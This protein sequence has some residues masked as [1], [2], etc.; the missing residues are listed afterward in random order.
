MD[1]D[2]CSLTYDQIDQMINDFIV[3]IRQDYNAPTEVTY[4]IHISLLNGTDS[5]PLDRIF[6][7]AHIIFNVL[8]HYVYRGETSC[9]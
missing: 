3:F 6:N 4:R 9:I 5:Y 1:L 7:S 2:S 8:Y